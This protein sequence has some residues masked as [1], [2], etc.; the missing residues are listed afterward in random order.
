LSAWR[1]DWKL[2]LLAGAATVGSYGII[3]IVLQFEAVSAVVAVR[4]ISVMMVVFWGCWKLGE[5]FGRQRMTAAIMIVLGI[6]LMTIG[7]V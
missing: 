2:A 1:A 7:R 5:S 4:Q 6:A 3:C